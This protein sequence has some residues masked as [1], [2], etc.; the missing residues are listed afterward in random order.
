MQPTSL[1]KSPC[2]HSR[3]THKASTMLSTNLSASSGHYDHWTKHLKMPQRRLLVLLSL[4]SLMMRH[5]CQR[6]IPTLQRL[7]PLRLQQTLHTPRTWPL[8]EQLQH[9]TC[10]A[11]GTGLVRTTQPST[12][13]LWLLTHHTP[14]RTRKRLQ[15]MPC[16]ADGRSIIHRVGWLMSMTRQPSHLAELQPNQ[17]CTAS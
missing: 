12:T 10:L 8:S 11:G 15:H 2:T 4:S 3:V 7:N 9:T 14:L 13:T 17:G 16:L 5:C 6:H 1:T